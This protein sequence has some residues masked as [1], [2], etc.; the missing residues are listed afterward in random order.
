MEQI[1]LQTLKKETEK[2]KK[3]ILLLRGTL[4]SQMSS[5]TDCY[6]EL[7]TKANT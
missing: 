2:K 7:K 3:H 4:Y 1:K 5:K 6:L